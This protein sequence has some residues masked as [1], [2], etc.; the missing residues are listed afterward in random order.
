M[1]SSM[2]R[3]VPAIICDCRG[4]EL[5][6]THQK[7]I[8]TTLNEFLESFREMD[9]NCD[10][11]QKRQN[12]L[13]FQ[14]NE[15]KIKTRFDERKEFFDLK[16]RQ[17]GCQ[18]FSRVK[19][20]RKCFEI[21]YHLNH[22]K[23]SIKCIQSVTDFKTVLTDEEAIQ[24]SDVIERAVKIIDMYIDVNNDGNDEFSCSMMKRRV[25]GGLNMSVDVMTEEPMHS[26]RNILKDKSTQAL[27]ERERLLK[28][29]TA[30]TAQLKK[31]LNLS[32]LLTGNVYDFE[33]VEVVDNQTKS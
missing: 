23:N 31:D 12:I 18:R 5:Q 32:I 24:L 13:V 9:V 10:D 30:F 1:S 20:R 16:D 21:V 7:L 6:K 17:F 8:E 33:T 2:V 15:L 27:A 28:D 19:I 22:R 14:L 3:T 29:L 25:N 11:R 26:Y 4:L